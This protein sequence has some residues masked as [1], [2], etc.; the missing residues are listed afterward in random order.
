MVM[1]MVTTGVSRAGHETY[2]DQNG[3]Q[4]HAERCVFLQVGASLLLWVPPVWA[5]SVVHCQ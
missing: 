4:A 2:C 1:A 5:M 3:Q